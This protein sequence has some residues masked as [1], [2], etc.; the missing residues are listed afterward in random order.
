MGQP[1]AGRFELRMDELSN[2]D[3]GRPLAAPNLIAFY[4]P[5]FYPTPYNDEWWGK[6]FTEWTNVV[7][8]RPRFEGHY[9]PHLPA[10]LGF[11]DLRLSET[12]E[13]QA[14]L[15]AEY[16]IHGFC[17]YH[18][19]FTGRRILERPLDEVL[20]S[21][22]PGLPFCICWANENWSRTWQ[23][24]ADTMLLEQ[25]Y[26][27]EDDLAHIQHLLPTLGDPRYIRVEGK[28]LLLIY[29][30]ELLPD[31]RRTADLWRSETQRAGLGDLFLVNVESNYV[32]DATDPGSFGFDASLKFQPKFTDFRMT[33]AAHDIGE[34][35]KK[36]F[37][38]GAYKLVKRF[39]P[40]TSQFKDRIFDYE[41]VYRNWQRSP[42]RAG[43]H[44]DCVTPMW[45]NSARRAQGAHI[46]KDSSPEKYEMW[47]RDAVG[48]S[49]P[50][51][52]GKRWVFINAWNEWGEGCHLEPCQKWGRAYLEATRRVFQQSGASDLGQSQ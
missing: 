49:A 22:K 5:Q 46:L 16:G 36:R 29:R 15:A 11:C 13:A 48:R 3:V 26:S 45:D 1:F 34:N 38:P 9:Q 30:I 28:L 8:G 31:I 47:L 25:H 2:V 20:A 41:E 50:D 44:F 33:A 4:L 19:W 23:G 18:Y 21:G 35:I 37:G 12:R 14:A 27:P 42:A 7:Q 32:A 43:A 17:Y 10:D 51:K 39:K 24:R 6:G 52:E 40:P